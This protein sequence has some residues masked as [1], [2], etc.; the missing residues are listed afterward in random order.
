M[1]V[2]ERMN[3]LFSKVLGENEKCAF[4][5]YLKTEGT[6]WPTQ[7]IVLCMNNDYLSVVNGWHP[8]ISLNHSKNNTI[9]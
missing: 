8:K 2:E 9:M 3:T 6:F 5:F 1:V 4:C 7:K